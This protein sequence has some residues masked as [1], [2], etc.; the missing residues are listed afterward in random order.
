MEHA[1]KCPHRIIACSKCNIEYYLK[2]E[3]IHECIEDLKMMIKNTEESVF[4]DPKLKLEQNFLKFNK[5]K[6]K[7]AKKRKE[8]DEYNYKMVEMKYQIEDR[9]E[10]QQSMIEE[11][12][13]VRD[14]RQA[15]LKQLEEKAI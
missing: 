15:D 13:K 4:T 7:L 3:D 1:S 9:M 10:E 12:L 5:F 14:H 11:L 8:I 6:A 2:Q